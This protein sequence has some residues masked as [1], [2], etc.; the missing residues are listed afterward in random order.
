MRGN[1]NERTHFSL[2]ESYVIASEPLAYIILDLFST[3]SG[4]ER[5]RQKREDEESRRS[6][7]EVVSESNQNTSKSPSLLRPKL[8]A[9]VWGKHI[10]PFL[11]RKELNILLS[12]GG[13][14]LYEA[15][16]NLKFPWP[17]AEL[18][19][20]GVEVNTDSADVLRA[21]SP[22][23]KWIIIAPVTGSFI[24]RP[25]QEPGVYRAFNGV[26]FFHSR[27][28]R[29]KDVVPLPGRSYSSPPRDYQESTSRYYPKEISISKDGRYLAVSYRDKIEVD[30]FLITFHESKAPSVSLNLHRTF[31]LE[32]TVTSP[33][34]L[35]RRSCHFSLSTNTKWVIVGY[36]GE[37][38][39]YERCQSAIVAWDI[40]T[41]AI[42]KSEVGT[43]IFDPLHNILATDSMIMWRGNCGLAY[44]LR[45]WTLENENFSNEYS[46][47]MIHPE[48]DPSRSEFTRESAES[49]IE[50]VRLVASP[51]DPYCF[52]AYCREF[53]GRD[54]QNQIDLFKLI[55]STES[56]PFMVLQKLRRIDYLPLNHRD[57][58]IC[59]YPEGQHLLLHNYQNRRFY[60]KQMPEEYYNSLH[61][62]PHSL[63]EDLV[64]K[65]NMIM[66]NQSHL[67]QV[68][69]F[70]LSP[71]GEL[72][73]V[74][75]HRNGYIGRRG[76]FVVSH[77][78]GN[79]PEEI[80]RRMFPSYY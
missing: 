44:G 37:S 45:A 77:C 40:E 16:R 12:Q 50:F 30:L 10:A 33:F 31:E 38:A 65:A 61:A 49:N 7:D 52:L 59:C 26:H 41:G 75:L 78:C 24:H 43:E 27:Y 13:K 47:Q 64:D 72:L 9:A 57:F 20:P 11:H 21:I 46:I 22:D 51:V 29:A 25:G 70:E 19:L 71:H 2:V 62:A 42:V 14:E 76:T 73:V 4:N 3:M 6:S 60:L 15:C 48:G 69:N 32:T 55:V 8:P 5:K 18:H 56:E 36:R 68:Q 66:Q 54:I 63:R 74:Q 35:I 58:E 34:Q 17:T 67:D 1:S 53:Q 80:R 39:R 23:S 28:G 79:T